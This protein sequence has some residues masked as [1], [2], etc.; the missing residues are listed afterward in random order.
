MVSE[1]KLRE[2]IDWCRRIDWIIGLFGGA[3]ATAA[4]RAVLK[5]FTQ[6]S[7][8][9]LWPICLAVATLFVYGLSWLPRR[10]DDAPVAG[11]VTPNSPADMLFSP[12]QVE[13]FRL[14]KDIRG[15]EATWK[16]PTGNKDMSMDEME[17]MVQETMRLNRKYASAYSLNLAPRVKK[18]MLELGAEGVN[19]NELMH[20][21]EGI[22]DITLFPV[23]RARIVRFAH[24][25]DGL[26]LSRHEW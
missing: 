2:F 16:L 24:A 10:K 21:T 18:L 25:L 13:A 6:L 17:S 1:K 20:F 8:L 9:W 11:G 19:A 23:L 4:M 22:A 14:E 12:L 7:A 5:T 26:E 15:F 3:A